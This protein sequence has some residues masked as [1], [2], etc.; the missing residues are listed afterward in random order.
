MLMFLLSWEKAIKCEA[1]RAFY[2]FFATNLI[3]SITLSTNVRFF[4]S[5]DIKT[6]LKSHFWC[7]TVGFYHM[8]GVKTFPEYL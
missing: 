3:N 8:R 7:E 5:Y 2:R 4:L 1:C 6:I